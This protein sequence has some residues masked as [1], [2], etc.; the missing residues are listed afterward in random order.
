MLQL[1]QGCDTFQARLTRL[2]LVESSI[3]TQTALLLTVTKVFSGAAIL[4]IS[5]DKGQTKHHRLQ[6]RGNESY[7]CS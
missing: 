4:N 7:D 6:E 2:Q 5:D 1:V 3:K